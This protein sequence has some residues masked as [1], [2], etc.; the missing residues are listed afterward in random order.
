M[1]VGVAMDYEMAPMI[2]K[3]YYEVSEIAVIACDH[4][5]AI[6]VNQIDSH[7]CASVKI[8]P[9]RLLSNILRKEVKEGKRNNGKGK[10]RKG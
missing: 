2:A 6:S 9:K 3:G 10:R 1:I 5:T 7:I 4:F 8:K